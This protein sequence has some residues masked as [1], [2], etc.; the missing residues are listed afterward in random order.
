MMCSKTP[1]HHQLQQ[2][3]ISGDRNVQK[4]TSI[5]YLQC[6]IS[7]QLFPSI[8]C[9]QFFCFLSRD[10]RNLKENYDGE[11]QE[12][13]QDAHEIDEDEMDEN[14]DD[15]EVFENPTNAER[16]PFEWTDQ[17]KMKYLENHDA[18]M[19]A[20]DEAIDKKEVSAIIQTKR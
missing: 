12:M 19:A 10:Y 2:L 9:K 17:R 3:M 13:E 11:Q 18:A 5:L 8:P 15:E 6:R 14:A 1:L 16:K 4:L 7:L 20:L